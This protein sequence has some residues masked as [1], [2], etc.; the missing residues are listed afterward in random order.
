VG[1][2]TKRQEGYLAQKE[3]HE[4]G[5]GV[6]SMSIRNNEGFLRRRSPLEYTDLKEGKERTK[7]YNSGVSKKTARSLGGRRGEQEGE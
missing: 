3:E 1:E 5:G 2:G 7:Q 4:I 6:P